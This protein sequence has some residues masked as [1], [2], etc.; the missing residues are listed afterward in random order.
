MALIHIFGDKPIPRVLDFF[1]V[2]Q[3]WD[4]SLRDVSEGTG[5]SYRTL[6][7]IIPDLVREGILEYSRT[8]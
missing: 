3:F 1:T 6:Q 7:G 5:V 2:N 8:E 4:Y